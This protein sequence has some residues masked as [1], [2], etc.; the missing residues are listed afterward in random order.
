MPMRPPRH[1]IPKREA[2]RGTAASRGYNAR[3]RRWRKLVLARDPAC[4]MCLEMGHVTPATV[5]DHVN[6]IDPANP[7]AGDWS[8]ENG[9][10]LCQTCHNRKTAREGA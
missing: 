5:A 8:L 6:P 4:V 7:A 3:H 1:H 10:G 2:E 9:Q